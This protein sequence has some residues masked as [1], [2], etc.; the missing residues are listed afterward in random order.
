M[1]SYQGRNRAI[2]NYLKALYFDY[3]E[4]TP[5]RVSL[6]PATWIRY[7]QDL[8]ALVLAHPRLFPGYEEGTRD[9]DAIPS[10]LYEE[11]RHTDCWG[12]VW[13]NVERGLD[14]IPVVYP[15]ADWAALDTYTP[16]DPDSDAQFGPHDWAAAQA[17]AQ[18][19]ERGDIASAG[20]PHGFVYMLLYYLR[21]FENFM[22]GVATAFPG[23]PC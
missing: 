18:A 2:I 21:G 17:L 8:E 15:L 4:W 9:F 19:R 22:I 11:G 14:S 13:N 5:C 10:P 1:L 12:I 20:L 6:M 16:P 7:R 23:I 3:P